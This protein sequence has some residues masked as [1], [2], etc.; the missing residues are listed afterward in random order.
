VVVEQVIRRLKIFRVLAE[1][2]RH[3]RRRFGLRLR[4]IAGLYNYGLQTRD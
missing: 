2:Y 3:R 1:R 4:L